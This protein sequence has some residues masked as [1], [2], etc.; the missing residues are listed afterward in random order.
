MN[1]ATTMDGWMSA[2]VDGF[3]D[4]SPKTLGTVR[5]L[6]VRSVTPSVLVVVYEDWEKH[7]S[8]RAFSLAVLDELAASF[9]S[10]RS[11]ARHIIV[12]DLVE[13][14]RHGRALDQEQLSSLNAEFPGLE[15]I[16]KVP[17]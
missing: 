7:V 15:W 11:V 1:E 13:P 2:F 14:T 6:G 3:S 17:V 5:L 10:P 9:P 8:A 16:G 12:G 4:V